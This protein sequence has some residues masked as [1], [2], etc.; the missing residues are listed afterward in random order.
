LPT[1]TERATTQAERSSPVASVDVLIVSYNTRSLLASCLESLERH[2]PAGLDLRVLVFDNAS[3]DGSADLVAERFPWAFLLRSDANL[4]FARANNLLL[5][6]TDGDYVMLLN[7]DTVL[8]EDIFSPLVALLEERPDAALAAPRLRNP[9]GSTQLSSQ[10][11]PTAASELALVLRGSKLTRLP[12]VW[13]CGRVVRTQRE[14]DLVDASG[15]R[16]SETIWAACWLLRGDE[17]RSFG[18]FDETFTTYDEDLDYCYRLRQRERKALYLPDVSL[19]HVG[20]ASSTSARKL[21]L[22]H[23]ARSHF[24]RRHRRRGAALVFERV[25]PVVLALKRLRR[26]LA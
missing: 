7:P 9:D 2:R 6:E 5:E 16:E 23:A 1:S 17:A 25:V 15:P 12:G 11:F 18:L 3:D 10:R 14:E 21:E 22:L 4:G 8:T 20:G 13:D 19:V 26:R 24:Y